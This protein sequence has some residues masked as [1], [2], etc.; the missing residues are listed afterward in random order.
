MP[1]EDFVRET[2]TIDY[3][4]VEYIATYDSFTGVG[5]TVDEA[6]DELVAAVLLSAEN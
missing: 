4:Y 5:D 2:A 3:D 1:L 6:L